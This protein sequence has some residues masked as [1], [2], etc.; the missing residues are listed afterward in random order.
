M[1]RLTRDARFFLDGVTK[2]LRSSNT[3]RS[4]LP[5]VSD[6]FERMT[7]SAKREKTA[8]VQSAVTLTDREKDE[9]SRFLSRLL[10]H[11]VTVQCALN[12]DLIGGMRIQI[13]DWVVDTSILRQIDDMKAMMVG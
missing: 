5:R 1:T 7:D 2:Y 4:M 10:T 8:I 9:V 11:P 3:G 13:G 6:A 12:R